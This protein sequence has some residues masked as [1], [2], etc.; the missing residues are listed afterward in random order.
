MPV[1]SVGTLQAVDQRAP[2]KRNPPAILRDAL[3]REDPPHRHSQRQRDADHLREGIAET[4]H[5]VAQ[6]AG[7]AHQRRQAQ[8]ARLDG[9]DHLV[10]RHRALGEGERLV[11]AMPHHR[12]VR[13]VAADAPQDVLGLRRRGQLLGLPKRAHGLVVAAGLGVD[14]A[15]QRVDRREVAPVAGRVEGRDGLAHLLPDDGGIADLPVADAQLVVGEADGSGV[16]R[17]LG[18]AVMIL[19]LWLTVK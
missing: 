9:R 7:E 10:Q 11:V 14:D 15:E 13:L 19:G 3:V 2:L 6:D 12:H 1:R 18:L 8:A 5:A 17:L 16:E 4:A